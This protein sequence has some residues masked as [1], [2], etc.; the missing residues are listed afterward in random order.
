VH[1]TLQKLLVFFLFATVAAYSAHDIASFDIWYHLKSGQLILEN[2]KI[3]LTNTFSYIAADHPSYNF[4]WL[5]QVIIYFLYSFSGIT[6]LIVFKISVLIAVFFLLFKMRQKGDEYIIPVSCLVL[7]TMTANERFIMRPELASYLL[8][9]L[10]FYILYQYRDQKRREIWA[11]VP[12]QILWANMHGFFVLGLFMVWAFLAGELILWKLWLPFE[13]KKESAVRGREYYRLLVVGIL[14]TA[15]TLITPYPHKILQTVIGMFAGLTGAATKGGPTVIDELI[16]PFSADPLFFYQSI[17]YYKAL[18]AVSAAAFLLN[19]RRLN[20]IHLLLYVG[21]L[22]ISVQARRNMCAFALVA[23]P[24]TFWNLGSFYRYYVES[25]AR[26]REQLTDR[27]RRVL[28]TGLILVML[29]FVYDAVSGRYY[30]R[31]RS[32]ARF[33]FGISKISYPKRAIDFIQKTN[34]QGN[35]FNDPA[36]GHYFTWRCFP[37]RMVFLD[38]RFDLPEQFLWHYFVPE[39]WPKI[40]EKYNINYVLLGHGRSSHLAGLV[41]MLYLHKDW[42][43]I[44]YDEMAVVFIRNAPENRGVVERFQVSFD[45]SQDETGHRLPRKNLFGLTDIPVAQFQLGNLYATFGLRERA[46]KEYEKCVNIFPGFWEARSN[47][48][49]MYWKVG[50]LENALRQYRMALEIKPNFAVV[51]V[52]LG[53]IYAAMGMLPQA[54]Q[55]YKKALKRKPALAAAHNGLAVAYMQMRDYKEAAREFET[56]LKLNPHDHRARQMLVYCRRMNRETK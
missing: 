45:T 44:Y 51:H 25:F 39:L 32:N 14:V 54:I 11:L 56:A 7:A 30:T 23:A 42:V 5:F 15:A 29:F 22:C 1:K 28:S 38:G 34:I 40:S 27:V 3:P 33:G 36:I 4:Y 9:S 8:L 37:E 31:D 2:F 46:I 18:V 50:R 20:I 35:I 53:D 17:F 48:G 55:S 49:D 47:L 12:L 19:F 21:F 10:Y 6:G 13:W 43:L 26:D 41:K 52:R 24:I 16:S